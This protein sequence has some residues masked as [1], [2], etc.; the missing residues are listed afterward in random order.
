MKETIPH[1]IGSPTCA[2]LN[3]TSKP[4]VLNL[5]SGLCA[6]TP[7]NCQWIPLL[8]LSC[9]CSPRKKEEETRFEPC[10]LT[11][12]PATWRRVL[13]PLCTVVMESGAASP[14]QSP[15]PSEPGHAHCSSPA[16][17]RPLRGKVQWNN[18]TTIWFPF[19]LKGRDT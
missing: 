12:I 17:E 9:C 15:Q 10:S 1:E 13:H 7:V 4:T 18:N 16:P 11:C 3:Y 5:L 6:L 14:V 19:V 8:S 2:Q